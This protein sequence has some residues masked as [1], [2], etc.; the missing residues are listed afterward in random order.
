MPS[1]GCN[2]RRP[3]NY[4]TF[5]LSSMSSWLTHLDFNW[6]LNSRFYNGWFLVFNSKI[7]TI[8]FNGDFLIYN[9]I[10][11]QQT[12]NTMTCWPFVTDFWQQS[13]FGWLT[14]YL[15]K[16]YRGILALFG[17]CS[18]PVFPLARKRQDATL[19][20]LFFKPGWFL[21]KIDSVYDR[22]NKRLTHTG[23]LQISKL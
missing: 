16:N 2:F 3:V 4:W 13:F 19:K 12:K 8:D 14:K 7:Y 18:C 5:S 20:N 17:R 9:R 11:K 23:H 21:L 6:L 1:V 15:S 22:K 10:D